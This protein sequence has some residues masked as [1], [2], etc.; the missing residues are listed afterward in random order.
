ME[1]MLEIYNINSFSEIVRKEYI[2][3]YDE[4]NELYIESLNDE[5]DEDLIK[6]SKDN[7]EVSL[8]DIKTKTFDFNE[9]KIFIDTNGEL[10]TMI[11]NNLWVDRRPQVSWKERDSRANKIVNLG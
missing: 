1:D 2:K 3:F 11:N 6:R 5:R 10:A 9:F 4:D 7:L 8:E